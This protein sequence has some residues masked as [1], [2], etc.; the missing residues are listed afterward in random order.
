MKIKIKKLHDNAK[1]P[2][3]GTA[4]AAGFDLYAT[5]D[6][7]LHYAQPTMVPTGLSFE[8]PEG[9]VGVV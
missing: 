8:I 9:H 6:T 3:R 4:S 5:E 7:E 1:M 2:T